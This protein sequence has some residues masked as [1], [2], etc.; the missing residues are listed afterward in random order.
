MGLD[1]GYSID[2]LVEEKQNKIN[3]ILPKN[4]N[5]SYLSK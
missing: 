2:K 3:K 4:T 5:K 1:S